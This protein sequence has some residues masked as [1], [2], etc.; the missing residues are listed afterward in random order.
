VET[1]A[2]R[3]GPKMASARR[4]GPKMASARVKHHMRLS[5]EARMYLDNRANRG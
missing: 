3:L 1:Y 5:V 2:R 4:L